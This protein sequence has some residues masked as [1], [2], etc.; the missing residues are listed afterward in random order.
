MSQQVGNTE[1]Y[2]ASD[3]IDDIKLAQE[4]HID[5]F[6]LNM[7]K[8]EPMN[9]KAIASV[10][11]HA[12][13][14]GFK[15]FF[16]FDYAGRGPYS[17]SEVLGWINRYASSG[18]YFRHNGQPLVSTFEGPEQAEDWID[19]KAQTGCFFVP[20]WS[21]LG[22]GPAV[23]AAGG[24]ADGLFS[25]A[26]WP[27]G[28]QDMDTYVDASYREALGSKPYMMPVSP[29]FY[30]NLPG[31]NKNWL[32]RGDHLWYDRWV[33]VNALMPEWVQIISWNDYGE[34][35]HIGPIRDHAL[36]AFDTGKAPYKYSLDHYGWRTLLPF[37]I[38]RY[39]TNRATITTEGVSFWYRPTPK[40]ACKTG[41]TTGNTVSQLQLEFQPYDIIDDAVFYTA[42]LTSSAT[43]KVI[44]GGVEAAGKWRDRAD[45][46]GAGLWH[47]SSPFDGRTGEVRIIV[48]RDGAVIADLTGPAIK[49]DC[50]NGITGYDAW[51]GGRLTS[52]APTP[53]T[54][55]SLADEVCVRGNGANDFAIMCITTCFWGYCP[56]TACVCTAMGT[57]ITLP[58]TT[59]AGPFYPAEG[60]NSN[61]IGLCN[62]ACTYGGCRE[63]YCGRT[64][65]PLIEPTV[66]PF[67]PPAC[68]SGT[69][70]GD[71]EVL[72]N[73]ACSHGFCPIARCRCTAQGHLDLFNPTQATKATSRIG[74]DHG[75][76]QFG[77]SRGFCP[78]DACRSSGDG[79]Q[80]QT[81]PPEPIEL[82]HLDQDCYR[83][84]ECVDLDNPQSSSCLNGYMRQG[85]DKASCSGDYVSVRAFRR[86]PVS[87]AFLMHRILISCDQGRPICC[88][89]SSVMPDA[90]TWRGSGGDCNGQ[91]H[92]GEATLFESRRGGTPGESGTGQCS[93][94]KKVFCCELKTFKTLTSECRWSPW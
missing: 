71:W 1:H 37:T 82:P 24:V 77:C 57:L 22:A 17:K 86:R 54:T 19:I 78:K 14:L 20:D 90:C 6:A 29:W 73:F 10:F 21:S 25:W 7:A 38:D 62:Y 84:T 53:V 41:G 75:L 42:L 72:C 40:N 13:T 46:G 65:Y 33:Q 43:V 81:S 30:T 51:A 58:K 11:S 56:E 28:S 2:T 66:S 34:S 55:P 59:F 49:N 31:Y 23:R 12:E 9:E 76:C 64:Q 61:Y 94:G 89:K 88:K 4:A 80:E 27:W 70:D 68:I 67:R 39:K 52:R 50:R 47:G 93:R 48:S 35:H 91:C 32:W 83:F 87:L 16:S 92:E 79:Q 69:G 60:L 74:D 8:G 5:A 18:A 3:W 44:I 63:Q 36:V 85:Y 45:G 26:G 15:L